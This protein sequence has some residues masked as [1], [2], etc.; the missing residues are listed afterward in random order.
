MKLIAKHYLRNGF[1]INLI[2]CIPEEL[3]SLII[4]SAS[5]SQPTTPVNQG[6]RAVRLQR[7]RLQRISRMARLFRLGRLGKVKSQKSSHLWRWFQKQ[8]GLGCGGGARPLESA[9]IAGTQRTSA[10][11]F[12][13]LLCVRFP[14]ILSAASGER[15]R[16]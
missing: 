10:L 7:M 3:V 5:G 1:G 2:A 6:V 14:A 16:P 9:L 13:E 4:Q 8:K 11:A 15:E 12:E